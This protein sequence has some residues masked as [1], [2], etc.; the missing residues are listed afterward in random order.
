MTKKANFGISK[1]RWDM[2]TRRSFPV[3]TE[4]RSQ[5]LGSLYSFEDFLIDLIRYCLTKRRMFHSYIPKLI[6]KFVPIY[7]WEKP[8]TRRDDYDGRDENVED[9]MKVNLSHCN[10]IVCN[11]YQKF[12]AV[13]GSRLDPR[14]DHI[15]NIQLLD[16]VEFGV[17][18]CDH[19]QVKDNP[20]RDFMCLEGGYGYYNYKTKSPHMKPK[21]PPGL[22]YHSQKCRKIRSEAD[23][24][25]P[26]DVLT[27]VIQRT[28]LNPSRGGINARSTFGSIRDLKSNPM[29]NLKET[30]R[31]TMSFYKNGEDMGFH[32]ENLVGPFHMCLNFYFV[33]SKLRLLSDYNI[34]K[35]HKFWSRMRY[36]GCRTKVRADHLE[37]AMQEG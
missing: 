21:Y 2:R 12:G 30:S 26:G 29:E 9:I 8:E 17:G 28:N 33:N 7:S 19:T 10:T 25:M 22:Y 5:S 36:N 18:I 11:G 6:V 24:C 3:H 15:I 32:V 37:K 14:L 20:R 13:L 4:V 16:G 34:R 27:M 31:Y 1:K 35:K 23:V